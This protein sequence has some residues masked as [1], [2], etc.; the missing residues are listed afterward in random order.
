V[1]VILDIVDQFVDFARSFVC[2]PLFSD[3]MYQRGFLT[4]LFV[5]FFGW[6]AIAFISDALARISAFF[7][8]SQLPATRP[9]P[10]GAAKAAGCG[11]GIV[12]LVMAAIILLVVLAAVAAAQFR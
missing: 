1:G 3:S 11:V 7:Q 12:K 2:V 5:G 10:S 8:P 9:G 6:K 4:A